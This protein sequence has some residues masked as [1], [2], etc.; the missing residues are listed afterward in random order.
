MTIVDIARER[1]RTQPDRMAYVFLA[2][3]ENESARWTYADLDRR[4]RRVAAAIQQNAKPGDRAVLL[5]PQNLDYVAAFLGCLY[6]GVVPAPAYPPRRGSRL[7]RLTA[8]IA[9]AAPALAIVADPL[10]LSTE[11]K[12]ITMT[13]AEGAGEWQPVTIQPQ[14]LAL[15]QYTSGSTSVPKGVMVTHANLMANQAAIYGAFGHNPDTIIMGWLPFYHDMGLIGNLLHPIFA[16]VPCILMPPMAFIQKPLRWLQAISRYR[17][18]TSGGPNFAYD[19]AVDRIS[20]QDRAQIDLTSWRVAFNGAEP[21]RASSLHRFTETFANCGFRESAWTP[22]YGLAESTLMV[23]GEIAAPGVIELEG[24]PVVSCGPPVAGTRIVIADTETG[25]P[26]AAG[27]EGEIWVSGESV[28]A[29]Y[30]NRAEESR[31]KFGAAVPGDSAS[32]LRTGDLGVLRDDRLYVSGRMQDRMVIRGRN[33]YPQDIEL[34]AERAHPDLRPNS[35][36]AFTLEDLDDRLVIVQECSGRSPSNPQEIL[37]AI[38]RAV[39][40]EHELDAHLICLVPPGA[41][42]RTTSGKI[43]RRACRE[44]LQNGS[45]REIARWTPAVPDEPICAAEGD[46]I[47]WA[48]QRVASL[49]GVSADDVPLDAPIVSLGLSSLQSMQLA[50]ELERQAGIVLRAV[51]VLAGLSIHDISSR[52]RLDVADIR[53]AAAPVA[54]PLSKNQE[55]LYLEERLHPSSGTCN[56]TAALA[57][58]GY[59][60]IERLRAA[61]TGLAR[62]HDMLRMFVSESSTGVVQ[63]LAEEIQCPLEV[64]DG[65]HWTAEERH[66]RMRE[67]ARRPFALDRA[68]LWGVDLFECSRDRST[69]ILRFHHLLLDLW[70]VNLLWRDFRKLYSDGDIAEPVRQVRYSDFVSRQQLQLQGFEGNALESYWHGKLGDEPPVLNLPC[71]TRSTRRQFRGRRIVRTIPEPVEQRLREFSASRATTL[72]TVMLAAFEVLLYRYCGQSEFLLGTP[73]AGREETQW[74]E[75]TGYFVNPLILRANFHGDPSFDETLA[76]VR[77]DLL[78]SLRYGAYPFASMTQRPG[79]RAIPIDAMFVYQEGSESLTAL[80]LGMEGAEWRFSELRARSVHWDPGI[81]Q[82]DLTLTAG[83]VSGSL[84][85]CLEY[86]TDRFAPEAMDA[87]LEHYAILLDGLISRPDRPVSTAR[88]LT[89]A[90]WTRQMQE[91]NSSTVPSPVSNSLPDL[92]E[93]QAERAPEAAAITDGARQIS[94]G[95][96]NRRANRLAR[97]LR[98]YGAGPEDRIVLYAERSAELL[99]GILAVLKSGAAYVPLDPAFPAD[100][101]AYVVNDAQPRLVL[102]QAALKDRIPP[103]VQVV[104]LEDEAALCL[105]FLETN[106]ASGVLPAN[107]AYIIYTSGS[108]GR[109]KGC[110]VTHANVVRLF[111]ATTLHFQFGPRDVWTLF[112]SAAF[113]FSVWEIWGAWLHGGRLVVVPYE[114]SRDPR[115]FA[116]LLQAEDVTVLSQTP[117]AFRQ[118]APAV[119]PALR[120]VVFGG[121]AL[122]FPLL[123]PWMD[124]ASSNAA[125]VNMYGITETT[126]HVTF[127]R[128][129]PEETW[130]KASRIG[131]GLEDL[132]VYLLDAAMQALPVG[133]PGEIYVGGPGVARGYLNRPGLT[134]ERFVPHPFSMQPGERLY[135]SGDLGRYTMEGDIEYLGRVDNQVQ[136]Y[137][138]R[139][140]LGEIES[141]LA[142]HPAISRAVVILRDVPTS[143]FTAAGDAADEPAVRILP[144]R[145]Y[146]KSE[147]AV[148]ASCPTEPQLVVYLVPVDDT[149]PAAKDLQ[150]YV[151]RQLPPYMVPARIVWLDSL[152]VTATGKVDRGALPA[153]DIAPAA[154]QPYAAPRNAIERELARIWSEVLGAPRVGIDDDYFALGGD[155]IRGIQVVG[156]AAASGIALSIPQLYDHQTIR[157]ISDS[158]GSGIPDAEPVVHTAAFSLIAPEERSRIPAGIEDAYP[159][160]RMQAGLLFHSGQHSRSSVY[161]AS[162]LYRFEGQSHPALFRLAAQDVV[163][164]HP[165][166][167]TSFDL[168]HFREPMQLVWRDVTAPVRIEDLRELGADEQERAMEEWFDAERET[169]FDPGRAPL[170]RFTMHQLAGEEFTIGLTCHDSI[171]DGWST[172]TILIQL[173][174]SYDARVQGREPSL[175]EPRAAY[176]DFVALERRD[177]GSRTCRN[178]WAGKLQDYEALPLP[179]GYAAQAAPGPPRL[180]VADVTIPVQLSDA[181][182]G[183]SREIGVPL[184]HVLLAAHLRVLERLTGAPDVLTGLEANGRAEQEGGEESVGQHLNTIPFR[185]HLRGGSWLELIRETYANERELLPYRR[186]PYA[187][188]QRY[189]GGRPLY[190]TT[191][192]YTHFHSF[193]ALRRLRAVRVIEGHGRELTH[194]ALKT[195]FNRDAFTDRLHLDVIFDASRM[196]SEQAH[197]IGESYLASLRAIV[198]DPSA[199]YDAE[200]LLDEGSRVRILQMSSGPEVVRAAAHLVELLEEQ[201]E[202]AP[203]QVAVRYQG[204]ELTCS[205]L[206]ARANRLARVLRGRGVGPEVLVGIYL[207]R[208]LELIVSLLAVLKAGGAYVPLDPD[209]PAERIQCMKD[210]AAPALVI[211]REWLDEIESETRA[212][213]A[214]P[215]GV[216]ILA[217]NAAYMIYTSGSTGKPKGALNT[218]AGIVNRL[219]WMQDAYCLDTSDRVLQKTPMGFDVSGWEFFWPLI[220]GAVLVLARPG[221]QNDAVYL[222]EV[223]ER[224]RI[225]TLHFV[226][227]ML[228]AFLD[229]PDL[230][231]CGS[232]RRVISSGEELTAGLVRRFHRCLAAKLY[233]LYGPTEAAIDV[234]AWEC[235]PDFVREP[236]PIGKPIAN[237]RIYVLDR[238]LNLTLP[239][240]PGE[241]YIAGVNV[242]RG[243]WRRHALT[244]ER[245]AP[246]P[247]SSEPGAR[248]YR[249]GDR[250]RYGADGA[251]EYLGRLDSQVK[252]RGVRI[253]LREVE[254]AI[255]QHPAV[256]AA[257]VIARAD[258]SGRPQLAAYVSADG[259]TSN[260]LRGHLAKELPA[261]MIPASFAFLENLPLTPSGKLDR[262][263]LPETGAPP[264]RL[265]DVLSRIEA[266]SQSEVEALLQQ[267][268]ESIR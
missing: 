167:R 73:A 64:H 262:R 149:R 146:L 230:E 137:G 51:D 79:Q 173:L 227:S 179:L 110:L 183:L 60:D 25:R 187:E 117:T 47:G 206:H 130:A 93:R 233:N 207:E 52:P 194:Y 74:S 151:R 24:R 223:I 128:I 67:I 145:R 254:A 87:L 184:K 231:R 255:E 234:T 248:M 44:A 153:T 260:E 204:R 43:R 191:F 113:D 244:A 131:R 240:V 88:L 99:I 36:A 180:G 140:E 186:Y 30:W 125:F 109:P 257:A 33:Y 147:A 200:D 156:R 65:S 97:L 10:P 11:L 115:A 195:E 198:R 14:E 72:Y 154:V 106:L 242:A 168:A 77:E 45:L 214:E 94:Y 19:L 68:P 158:L 32:Y 90:E 251:V 12:Q 161:R 216:R 201:A 155:S 111:R 127:R 144:Y 108:T 35:G 23:S 249:T 211:N 215:L 178:Y 22:C 160:A 56:V 220:S 3:G 236:I 105:E 89:A 171:L 196:G 102:T 261:F 203:F 6:A 247:F 258:A 245:F 34:A 107:L 83:L 264:Q 170:I 82:R 212:Q 205:E 37:S 103:G 31:E 163:D 266:L 124:L 221:G 104:C 164:R 218:H 139:I 232:L 26:C 2:D 135:R 190:D 176:R 175:P 50:H 202:H 61:L 188:I 122:E 159:M 38:R 75:V 17:A 217:A 39:G 138:Y 185:Q 5:L 70:S 162:F 241:I 95:E 40:Q 1:A 78:E 18:T 132:Q 237:T 98:T 16:G 71:G 13:A 112:H 86:D 121:E 259:V 54:F 219:L 126:V 118:L 193:S 235:L 182:K 189:Q 172:S 120:W 263:R 114:I 213:S 143:H 226:P 209:Y 66:A 250:G 253:E 15:L 9:D 53:A 224:E 152:P 58:D 21:V 62:G 197:S 119:F 148:T 57:L 142:A 85:I 48:R 41:V 243:Y 42:P 69:L 49:L 239:G 116:R 123:R 76:R 192:N 80:A 28:A 29:G 100:R 4:A 238:Y 157:G 268:E 101:V 133:I 169:D 229:Q 8:M 27:V 92:F 134:A 150:D 228:R 174:E 208:S 7:D 246:D 96:L 252:I 84:A 81:A 181:L 256:R 129:A 63:E 267:E 136:L 210:D 225:T 20:A 165:I 91:W 46:V 199:A 222:T 177:C 166:L 265:E 59:V 141:V 55:S